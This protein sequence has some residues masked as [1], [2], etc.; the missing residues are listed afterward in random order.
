MNDNEHTWGW[1]EVAAVIVFGIGLWKIGDW[2]VDLIL[3]S[4]K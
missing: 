3:W 4:I 2:I 1:A